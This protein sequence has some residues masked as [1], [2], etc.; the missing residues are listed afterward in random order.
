LMVGRR[1]CWKWGD[2]GMGTLF[3]EKKNAL[4][5]RGRRGVVEWVGIMGDNLPDEARNN[6]GKV[7][8]NC[9]LT[10]F[11]STSLARLLLVP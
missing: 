3:D 2:L 1:R 10:P 8:P 6:L 9:D 7:I 4:R 5:R 11:T